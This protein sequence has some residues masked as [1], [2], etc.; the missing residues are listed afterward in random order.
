MDIDV[1]FKFLGN[2]GL[3]QNVNFFM[4]S[5]ST[6]IS[7]LHMVGAALTVGQ[8]DDYRCKTPTGFTINQTI[9]YYV[10]DNGLIEYDRCHLYEVVNG[11]VSSNLTG[12]RYG[13]DYK[14]T[15]GETS[16]VSDLNLV[17]DESLLGGAMQSI[18]HVGTIVG[19][20]ILG[21]IS[22]TVGRRKTLMISLFGLGVCGTAVAF[23]W[24]YTVMA[25]L[26]FI[27]GFW[28]A[29][30]LT[31]G[32]VRAIEMFQ[33]K[34]RMV[35]HMINGLMYGS[36]VLLVSP[37][38]YLFP[39]W[40]HFQL[41]VSLPCFV[42]VPCI[43]FCYESLRWLVQKGRFK[44]ADK[45]ILR[46]A[47]SKQLSYTGYQNLPTVDEMEKIPMEIIKNTD[48]K[49][50]QTGGSQRK[51]A[52]EKCSSLPTGRGNSI[53]SVSSSHH[54]PSM[55]RKRSRRYS[56]VDLFTTRFMAMQTL[57]V[58]LCW[59]TGSSVYFGLIINTSNLAGN[60]YLTF[61]LMSLFEMSCY[62]VDFFVMKRFGR[63]RPLI[64]NFI[65]SGVASLI[66]AFTPKQTES[67]VSL[68]ALI[69][70]TSIIGRYFA[71][72]VFDIT[73]LISVEIFPTVLR[74]IG[75][76]TCVTVGRVGG[77]IAPFVV[78]LNTVS[79]WLPLTIF[80]A[81][82]IT[83]GLLV[84]LLPETRHTRL[85]ETFEDAVQLADKGLGR[86]KFEP[87]PEHV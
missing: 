1:V 6:L 41:A 35:G 75:L 78:Y 76:G 66:V 16:V 32:Y 72:A 58:F 8:P 55:A 40:R 86:A 15:N 5:F 62:P 9:P 3:L 31:S 63:K 68:V 87:I 14:T 19:S 77:V 47:K 57:I 12:C 37:L 24:N 43:W 81:I 26:Y 73:Y 82:S 74:N 20:F 39:N 49:P 69:V 71:A 4:F 42:L 84:S 30:V 21:Q 44:E 22:D 61:F 27:I 51:V 54:I 60:K 33:T 38:A 65:G 80:G 46:I 36:G 67:G 79:G 52:D 64:T 29:G 13:Y 11:S 23:L 18:M 85:P 56:V 34:K 10:N 48:S 17:C 83:S 7:P 28:T 50:V 2:S 45:I 70:A 53:S 59:F 25:V